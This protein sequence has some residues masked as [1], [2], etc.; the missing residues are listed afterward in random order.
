MNHQLVQE[1]MQRMI[2]EYQT[3][4]FVLSRNSNINELFNNYSIL[5][6]QLQ[7]SKGIN[8]RHFEGITDKNAIRN[9]QL[10]GMMIGIKIAAYRD[11][12]IQLS[13]YVEEKNNRGKLLDIYLNICIDDTKLNTRNVIRN[14]IIHNK[15]YNEFDQETK[16]ELNILLREFIIE[17]NEVMNTN[18]FQHLI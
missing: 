9:M 13:R 7:S 12:I 6:V 16:R 18:V 17:S 4:S 8:A 15:R 10:N 14:A 3:F 11:R 1:T 5:C 2:C